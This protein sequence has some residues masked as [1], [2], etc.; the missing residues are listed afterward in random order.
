LSQERE[1]ENGD[2]SW[3]RS[4]G[5]DPPRLGRA[6]LMASGLNISTFLMP[7][8][9]QFRQPHWPEHH[10]CSLP[11]SGYV[12]M[13]HR[14]MIDPF[15]YPNR[16]HEPLSVPRAP[17]LLHQTKLERTKWQQTVESTTPFCRLQRAMIRF[18][19]IMLGELESLTGDE[20]AFCLNNCVCS[21]FPSL[22][23][24][25]VGGSDIPICLNRVLAQVAGSG[26][27]VSVLQTGVV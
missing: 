21:C 8:A 15:P 23:S 5:R 17:S 4:S 19:R 27:R 10:L 2:G 7:E 25:L 22:V 3:H 11:S 12:V 20:I 9:S 6:H 1:R 13:Q 24:D 14:S 18:D 26:L 16:A